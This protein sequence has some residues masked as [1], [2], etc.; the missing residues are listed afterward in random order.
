[1]LDDTI[2]IEP[3][4]APGQNESSS[5]KQ[6]RYVRGIPLARILAKQVRKLR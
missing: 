1:M 5:L 2:T 3:E 4:A 6:S